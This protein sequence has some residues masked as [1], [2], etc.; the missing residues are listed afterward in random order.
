MYKG[1]IIASYALTFIP[2]ALL[3]LA[4]LQG[5]RRA[6]RDVAALDEADK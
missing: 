1:Y 5:W 3:A 4:S 2:L 6:Q